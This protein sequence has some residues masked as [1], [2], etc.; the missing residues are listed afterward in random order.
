VDKY[1]FYQANEKDLDALYEMLKK[2]KIELR[3]LKLPNISEEKLFNTL[4][5]LIT[6]GKIICC[7]LNESEKIIGAIA[8]FKTQHWWS[9]KILYNI[10]FVYVLPEHRNF[11]IFRNLLGSVKKI[12]KDDP[13]SLSI[14]TKLNIDPVLQK[15]GFEDMG[16]NW[17]L[18]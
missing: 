10:H 3:N 18:N 9:E 11:I 16:K 2:F 12:A 7:N 4:E 8:F 5:T 15:L 14:S 17:R 6:K 13:I 1:K